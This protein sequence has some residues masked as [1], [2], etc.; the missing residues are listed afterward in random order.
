M[1]SA[2]TRRQM[3]ASG[4]ALPLALDTPA[5]LHAAAPGDPPYTLSIN[6][7]IM[8]P[9]TMPRPDR[10]RAVAAQGFRAYSFWNTDEHEQDAMLKVQQE[11][12]I[13]CASITGPGSSISST[14]LTKPGA[15]QT[16]LDEMAARAKMAKKFGGAQSIIF[17]GRVHPDVPWET[18]RAQI[19]A[20]LKQC[21]EIAKE[22]GMT[23]IVE[24]LSTNPGQ[25]RMALDTAAAAFPVVEEV[26]HPNVKVCF[27]MYHLQLM[28]GNIT[29]HLRQGISKNLIGLVQIGEVPGRKEPGTGEI[30]YAYM[31]RVL[32]ELKWSGYVDTEMGTTTTPEAAVQ[33]TR[34]MSLEN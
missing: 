22:Q 17:V 27:D 6:I 29:A 10:I 20:G 25:V 3:I 7:E 11:T 5:P 19:V 12:G 31:M 13:K 30:D 28:E 18:Q 21:G 14:G 32:R 34:K 2:V 33:L 15:Q 23:F 8:F 26:A 4:A 24:P 9:R 1:K 16:F